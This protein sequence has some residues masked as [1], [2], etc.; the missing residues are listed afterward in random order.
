[1]GVGEWIETNFLVFQ[2]LF[3]LEEV[4]GIARRKMIVE[5]GKKRQRRACA[6]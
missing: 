3:W 1:V 4:V 6:L 5:T 2:P